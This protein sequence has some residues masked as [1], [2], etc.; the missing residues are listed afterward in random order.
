[1]GACN[2]IDE[3]YDL[4]CFNPLD[5]IDTGLLALLHGDYIVKILFA[6]IEIVSTLHLEQNDPIEFVHN[7]DEDYKFKFYIID[8]AGDIVLNPD[9]GEWFCF[10]SNIKVVL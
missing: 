6:G 7:L 3:C 8:P 5:T 2:C 1:M 10:T 4:G 9:G